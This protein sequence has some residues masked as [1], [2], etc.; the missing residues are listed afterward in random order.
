MLDL[1]QRADRQWNV[2]VCMLTNSTAL[3]MGFVITPHHAC[4]IGPVPG[5]RS[6]SLS[7]SLSHP[8]SLSLPISPSLTTVPLGQSCGHTTWLLA[9]QECSWQKQPEARHVEKIQP[10][11][12][13][14]SNPPNSPHPTTPH[15]LSLS[16]QSTGVFPPSAHLWREMARLSSCLRVWIFFATLWPRCV[17]AASAL[18]SVKP[19]PP[20]RFLSH[21]LRGA[22][23]FSLSVELHSSCHVT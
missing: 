13:I 1:G 12:S 11:H 10:A 3:W 7:L 5:P 14:H 21:T 16:N 20:P 22:G 8:A 19:P 23:S 2:N 15:F 18:S 9:A 17:D 6:F 4:C